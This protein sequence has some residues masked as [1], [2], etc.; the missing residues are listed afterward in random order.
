[1][2]YRERFPASPVLFLLQKVNILIYCGPADIAQSRQLRQVERAILIGRIVAQEISG[3]VVKCGLW[4]ADFRA[5][6]FRVPHTTDN[7]SP[8]NA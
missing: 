1:M 5:F 7:A 3:N 8:Y 4:S 6:R 2:I